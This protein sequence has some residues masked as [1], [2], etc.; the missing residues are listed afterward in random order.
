MSEILDWLRDN[1]WIVISTALP[2]VAGL[3]AFFFRRG[4]RER[5]I[6]RSRSFDTKSG[7]RGSAVARRGS[8]AHSRV[9]VGRTGSAE[10]PEPGRGTTQ[11]RAEREQKAR[12]ANIWLSNLGAGSPL[13]TGRPVPG[14]E[15]IGLQRVARRARPE[16]SGWQAGCIPSSYASGWRSDSAGHGCEYHFLCRKFARGPSK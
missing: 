14:R 1:P 7:S 2:V 6:S 12:Y 15:P 16:I 8:I 4:V 9:E 3:I 5:K 10:I 13:D 11:P